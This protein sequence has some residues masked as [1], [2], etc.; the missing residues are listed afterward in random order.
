MV[1]LARDII[2]RSNLTGVES[3]RLKELGDFDDSIS[4]QIQGVKEHIAQAHAIIVS[5]CSGVSG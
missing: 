5:I 1:L 4:E 3:A 2:G